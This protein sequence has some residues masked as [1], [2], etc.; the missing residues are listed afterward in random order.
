M[1]YSVILYPLER[2]IELLF[3][4]SS[5]VFKGNIAFSVL[6]LSLLVSLLTLPLYDVAEKWENAERQTSASLAPMLKRIKGTFKG[7]ERYMMINALYR[8]RHY[9]PVMALRSSLSLIIMVPFFIAAC[10]FLNGQTAFAGAH[11]LFIRDLSKCDRLCRIGGFNV[12]ILPILMTAI[13]VIA[14][15]V[16]TKGHPLKERVMTLSLAAIFLILLYRSPAALVLYWTMNNVFSLIKNVFY[17]LR[18]PLRALYILTALAICLVDYYLLFCHRGNM[19]KRLL[20]AFCLSLILFAPLAARALKWITASCLSA[21]TGRGAASLCIISC[22]S[23][24]ALTGLAIPCLVISSSVIEF[25]GIDGLFPTAFINTSFRQSLGL[26][27]LWPLFV[28]FLFGGGRSRGGAHGGCAAFPTAALLAASSFIM[29]LWALLNAFLF[30]S[31]YGTLTRLMTYSAN[32]AGSTSLSSIICSIAAAALTALA[33]LFA[34]RRG[35]NR[36]LVSAGIVAFIALVLVSVLC[37]IHIKREYRAIAAAAKAFRDKNDKNGTS[38]DDEVSPLLH[39]SRTGQNVVLL[40]LDNAS[41]ALFP[42]VLDA[43]PDAAAAL[44][45]FT[46]YPNTVSFGAHTIFGAPPIYGGYEYTPL[47]MNKRDAP[48]LDKNNE[49][50]LM[51]PRIFTEQASFS[52]TVSDLSWANYS[53]IPDMSICDP[54]PLIK[55]LYLERTY[56][57]KWMASHPSMV[58]PFILSRAIKRNLLYVSIFRCLP[59]LLREPFYDEGRWW[60]GKMAAGDAGEFIDYYSA[61][62]YMPMMTAADS[63]NNAYF[64][65]VNET[66]H[67]KLPDAMKA[68]L[69]PHSLEA[70]K[71]A[72][73]SVKDRALFYSNVLALQGVARWIEA[74]KEK[75]IYDNTRIVIVSDHGEGIKTLGGKKISEVSPGYSS[76]HLHPLLL[77]KDFTL[78]AGGGALPS[79]PRPLAD[80]SFMTTADVPSILLSGIVRNAVNPFTLLKIDSSAKESGAVVTTNPLWTPGKQ[81]RTKFSIADGEWYTARGTPIEYTPY[82]K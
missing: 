20:M 50:L 10:S 12:N 73:V 8:E 5:H 68:L 53:W 9:H 64:T 65:I 54:Y 11:F 49:A 48:L 74:L 3:S 45:D 81:G 80:E 79:S 41:S 71:D 26:F 42:A 14:C 56:A 24:S 13:N 25:C 33:V 77:V 55:P 38:L 60:S 29:L 76:D 70:A 58:E 27:V 35:L 61:L 30:V 15:L 43:A 63:S 16:Y 21:M 37:R 72:M 34:I 82:K 51:L 18:R 6:S 1:L 66:T 4:I 59:P 52:A 2:L 78:A 36:V 47:E 40:M 46:Y 28:F 44:S 23:M 62:S 31:R 57:A 7:D 69:P 39:F 32:I 17:R 67:E 19:N 75:G 22:L